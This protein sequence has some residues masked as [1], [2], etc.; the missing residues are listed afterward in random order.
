MVGIINAHTIHSMICLDSW[1]NILNEV[2]F[3]VI[4]IADFSRARTGH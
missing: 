2:S 4:I 1:I 3:L